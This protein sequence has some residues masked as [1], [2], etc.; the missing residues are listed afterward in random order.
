LAADHV[1][2]HVK[3][4][5]D[6]YNIRVN[7]PGEF[8]VSNSLAALAVGRELGLTPGQ[9]EK[10]IA[11]L[12]GVEGRMMIVNEGQ[13]FKVIIDFASTPDAFERLFDAVRP[14]T[15]GKLVAVFGSAGRRDEAKRAIQGE[16][17]GRIADEV[18][19]TE[20]DDRDIDGN[21]ILQQIASG[22]EK[23]GKKMNKNMFLVHDRAE[24]IK[25][26]MTRVKSSDDTVVILG[27]GHEKT[28]ERAD[29]VHPWSEIETTREALRKSA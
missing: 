28:I 26:A 2:Y 24:A 19:L 4:G 10:G 13:K 27:K 22:A 16:I 29:G 21:E 7:I 11:A 5:N 1:A 18:V 3:A 9:I 23:A 17:A 20:E 15:K 8:N 25:F 6:E 12:E 14:V